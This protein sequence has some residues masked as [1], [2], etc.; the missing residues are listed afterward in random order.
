MSE[1]IL[2]TLAYTIPPKQS[3][4]ETARA[5]MLIAEQKKVIVWAEPDGVSMSA[6]PGENTAQIMTRWWSSKAVRVEQEN[7]ERSPF[8]DTRKELA[9]IDKMLDTGPQGQM[10]VVWRAVCAL[11]HAVQTLVDELE[12]KNERPS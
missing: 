6:R 3:P 10:T 9:L 2:N 4:E 11:R 5:M 12:T 7:A 1:P 8:K